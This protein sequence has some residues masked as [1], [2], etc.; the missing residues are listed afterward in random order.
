MHADLALRDTPED[1]GERGH[2]EDVAQAFA[3]CLQQ[4]GELR[5]ARSHAQQV[6]RALALLP[7]WGAAI[8]PAARQQQGAGISFAELRG[9]ERG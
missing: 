1:F 4:H 7:Q 2:V 5:I 6:I 8:G 3:V 9:K